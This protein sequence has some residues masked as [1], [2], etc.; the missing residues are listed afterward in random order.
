[1]FFAHL[2]VVP[3]HCEVGRNVIQQIFIEVLF[4]IIMLI[5][6]LHQFLFLNGK[7]I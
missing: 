2:Y 6:L 1:L 7:I 3:V 5:L 4:C